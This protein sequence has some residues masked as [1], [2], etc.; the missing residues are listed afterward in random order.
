MV[1]KHVVDIR[2]ASD[3]VSGQL[4]KNFTIQYLAR[5]FLESGWIAGYLFNSVLYKNAIIDDTN[6]HKSSRL[7]ISF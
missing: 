2:G 6:R 4:V 1:Y 3:I 5:Y 7:L